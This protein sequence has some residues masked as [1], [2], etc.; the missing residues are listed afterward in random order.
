MLLLSTVARRYLPYDVVIK[1]KQFPRHWPFVQGIHW[2]PL[3]SPHKGHCR[4]TLMFSLICVWINGW[5]Y[6]RRAGDLRQHRAHYDVAVMNDF[7]SF[8]ALR[9]V[10]PYDD[11][12]SWCDI[13]GRYG[14]SNMKHESE[15]PSRKSHTNLL[16]LKYHYLFLCGII[17]ISFCQHYDIIVQLIRCFL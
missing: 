1:L 16:L 12:A 7:I 3:N 15:Y 4:E 13:C 11:L 2:S 14:S 8:M 6:N 9:H 17:Y 10:R 5:V